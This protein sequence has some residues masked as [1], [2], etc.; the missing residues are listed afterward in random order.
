MGI[1]KKPSSRGY[2]ADPLCTPEY[3]SVSIKYTKDANPCRDGENFSTEE[4][5]EYLAADA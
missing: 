1:E 5:S 3:E 4:A 2:F